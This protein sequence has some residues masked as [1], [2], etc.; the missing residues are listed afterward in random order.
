MH[1]AKLCRSKSTYT[2]VLKAVLNLGTVHARV[3]CD[4]SYRSILESTNYVCSKLCGKLRRCHQNSYPFLCR[5]VYSHESTTACS[6]QTQEFTGITY[7]YLMKYFHSLW[8]HMSIHRS[9]LLQ[10]WKVYQS[11][12]FYMALSVTL[13][14]LAIEIFFCT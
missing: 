5:G 3:Y 13:G 9:L 7:V 12:I 6:V 2:M 4:E 1:H 10:V 14:L 11:H 8:L